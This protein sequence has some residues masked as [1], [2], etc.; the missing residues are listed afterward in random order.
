MVDYVVVYADGMG[1]ITS[2]VVIHLRSDIVEV[3]DVD[4]RAHVPGD[5]RRGRLQRIAPGAVKANMALRRKRRSVF[6][7]PTRIVGRSYVVPYKAVVTDVVLVETRKR[8]A[9]YGRAVP[10]ISGRHWVTP[11]GARDTISN[12]K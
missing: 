5:A 7:L 10:V 1:R 12:L 6:V 3:T 11:K 8:A 2:V 9:V 4:N